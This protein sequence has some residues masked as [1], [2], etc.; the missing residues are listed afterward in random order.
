MADD[1]DQLLP[2]AIASGGAADF[3][4]VAEF[5][6]LLAE[7]NELRDE[8]TVIEHMPTDEFARRRRRS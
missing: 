1:K 7:L 5:E 4:E 2:A 6:A 3:D 8:G